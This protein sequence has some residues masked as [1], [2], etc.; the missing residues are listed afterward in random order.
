MGEETKFGFGGRLLVANWQQIFIDLSRR[1]QSMG[2]CSINP[3]SMP[4]IF[5]EGGEEKPVE[6]FLFDNHECRTEQDAYDAGKMVIYVE[7]RFGEL[8][9]EIER[10]YPKSLLDISRRIAPLTH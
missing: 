6:F 9:K 3:P 7:V 1:H 8:L 10:K 4:T 2:V 5:L